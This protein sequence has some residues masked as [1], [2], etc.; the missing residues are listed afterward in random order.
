MSLPWGMHG[1]LK[2]GKEGRC[3]ESGGEK[4][5]KRTVIANREREKVR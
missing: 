5:G 1:I 4:R 2:T 3:S